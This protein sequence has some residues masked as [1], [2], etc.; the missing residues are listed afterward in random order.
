MR[1]ATLLMLPLGF[2]L[3][4]AAFGKDAP[5][6]APSAGTATLA[7][8]AAIDVAGMDRSVAPGDDFFKFA[9]GAWI[10][11]TEI[12]PDRGSF[13]IGAALTDAT[14]LR[15]RDL[16]E[17]AGKA[18]PGSDARRVGDYYAGYMD[19]AA[20][21]AVGT[22]PL[23]P[24]LAEIAA[25]ADKKA[26]AK[27]LGSGLRADVD[28]L[29]ATNFSTEHL[30]GLWVAPAFE[31]TT[32]YEP[33]L[34]QGGL[35]M[36]DR[37]YYLDASPRMTEIRS[38]YQEHVGAIL[39]LAGIAD[40]EAKAVRILEL[41]KRM[42]QAH[43]S[44]VDSE[45]VHK[46]NNPWKREEFATRAPGLDW[47]AYFEAAG[48][49]KE[50]QFVVW[51]PAA[52]TGLSALVASEPLDVWKDY[53]AFHA[54]NHFAGVL[55]KAFVD[56]QF[57][58]YGKTLFGTPQ[59][60]DRWKRALASTNAAIGQGVGKLYAERYFSADS[61]AKAAALVQ[62]LLA[63]FHKRIAALSWMTPET[64][65]KALEK[66]GTLKVGVGYPDRWPSYTGLAVVKA[67]AYGNAERAELFE[68]R[69]RVAELRQPVDKGEWAMTP[70]EVN[71]VN[72]PLQN[73]LNFPA[74]ILQPPFFHPSADAAANYGAIGSV[75]GHEIVHSFDD[76]G[77]QFD[78]EGRLRNWWTPADLEHFNAAAERLAAQY[79]AYHPFPDA[80]VNGHQ[81]LSE[82]I[83]DVAGLAAAF[84]AYRISLAGKAAA[85]RQGFSGDQHFFVSF[86][87]SWR[88]KSREQSL[89]AQLLV[90]GHAP[91]EYRADT[92]RNLD[93]WY[94]A[95]AA[96]PGQTLYLAPTERVN[97][98]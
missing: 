46:A 68:Y 80:H 16:V 22:A 88:G 77:C 66:L 61:K 9:N 11:A 79:D 29:N 33:Y 41:E 71:A 83:A 37:E 51:Q 54:A 21:E 92:V 44:R 85:E 19:E 31:D 72:L 84:D 75:I 43:A 15:I 28:P 12:P 94:G 55:P 23:K 32:H 58:F 30:F 60:R 47:A 6:A 18:A 2:I 56:E 90:D 24:A 14:N 7:Q 52:I 4:G 89:R 49:A 69:H 25:V 36:P 65:A 5:S 42:A 74:A 67:D 8:T 59:N 20:I 62:D 82:N 86:A 3:L 35:G 63:A 98:W 50:P 45:D 57:S 95:F 27:L 64:K 70:Q 93:A 48:L 10:Q 53:L 81:T 26:L 17:A 40:S 78:A 38:K 1:R 39:K 96:K 34:L 13:G 73:A 87:Q 76:Q 91:A 97:V